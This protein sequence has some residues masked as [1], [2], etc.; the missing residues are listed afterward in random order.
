MNLF[1]YIEHLQSVLKDYDDV[2]SPTD[3]FFMGY[4]PDDQRF[5]ICIKLDE[6]KSQAR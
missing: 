3:D 1:A 6:K 5:S 4:F 2:L